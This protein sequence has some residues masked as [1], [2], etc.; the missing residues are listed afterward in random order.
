[1]ALELSLQA[2]KECDCLKWNHAHWVESLLPSARDDPGKSSTFFLDPT[3][4]SERH[5]SEPRPRPRSV[6]RPTS[7]IPRLTYVEELIVGMRFLHRSSNC[8]WILLEGKSLQIL[9]PT[10]MLVI[11]RSMKCIEYFHFKH[12][13]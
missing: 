9:D 5:D 10:S 7:R 11:S 13:N 8:T 1:M 2:R 12:T 6:P 3:R 4:E